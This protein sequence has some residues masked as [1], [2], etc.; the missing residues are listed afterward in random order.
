M[1]SSHLLLSIYASRNG[2]WSVIQRCACQIAKR[3]TDKEQAE[4]IF[5]IACSLFAEEK[6]QDAIIVAE[7][8]KQVA[9]IGSSLMEEYEQLLSMIQDTL[10][11]IYDDEYFDNLYCVYPVDVAK[12]CEHY[13]IQIG[14][15]N[16]MM[17]EQPQ[18]ISV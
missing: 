10:V 15:P 5:H 3:K 8:G 7:V 17:D 6:F 2:N 9:G 4:Y 12:I 14:I 16:I 1:E 11:D 13:G 18:K